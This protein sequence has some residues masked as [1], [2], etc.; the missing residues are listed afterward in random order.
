M[1]I[2]T[3]KQSRSR[4]DSEHSTEPLPDPSVNP[5]IT[6]TRKRNNLSESEVPNESTGIPTSSLSAPSTPAPL[7]PS[8]SAATSTATTN[9]KSNLARTAILLAAKRAACNNNTNN[10]DGSTFTLTDGIEDEADSSA[11]LFKQRFDIL[12][13]TDEFPSEDEIELEPNTTAPVLTTSST[14]STN[15][16]TVTLTDISQGI[17]R[18]NSSFSTLTIGELQKLLQRPKELRLIYDFNNLSRTT[19]IND[20][21]S[22]TAFLHYVIQMANQC[23]TT[24]ADRQSQLEMKITKKPA[25]KKQQLSRSKCFCSCCSHQ[26]PLG[27]KDQRRPLAKAANS[28]N[29]EICALLQMPQS[30]PTQDMIMGGNDDILTVQTS[31]QGNKNKTLMCYDT[32]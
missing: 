20:S 17:T 3:D 4:S 22:S 15:S 10:Y 21:S 8:T 26:H 2:N 18:H 14:T 27:G 5:Q 1:S 16:T 28:P 31:L 24:I 9:N 7:P 11:G 25:T 12:D 6:L 13:F 23:L 30:I 32:Y 19:N 29:A